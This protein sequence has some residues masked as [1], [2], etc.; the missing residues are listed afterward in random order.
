MS[1]VIPIPFKHCNSHLIITNIVMLTFFLQTL[2]VG[3]YPFKHCSSDLIVANILMRTLAL[4]A[5]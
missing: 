4:Q 1:I 5:L 3:T 2:S